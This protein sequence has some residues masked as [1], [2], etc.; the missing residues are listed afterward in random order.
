MA[1]YRIYRSSGDTGVEVGLFT[2]DTGGFE[3]HVKKG[4]RMVRI[5][6]QE[7]EGRIQISMALRDPDWY[8]TNG[9]LR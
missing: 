7:Q 4:S 3:L 6:C 9:R 5:P 2:L 8:L 1:E